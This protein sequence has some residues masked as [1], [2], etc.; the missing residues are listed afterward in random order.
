MQDV[1]T[2]CQQEQTIHIIEGYYGRATVHK[3]TSLPRCAHLDVVERLSAA[4]TGT[5]LQRCGTS[6][7]AKLVSYS[8]Y[9][10]GGCMA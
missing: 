2:L 9:S 10:P 1:I 8:H 5:G 7:M 6:D 4:T 3:Y